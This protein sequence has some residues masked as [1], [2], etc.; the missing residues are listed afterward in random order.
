MVK[1]RVLC[2]NLIITLLTVW[3]FNSIAAEAATPTE[4]VIAYF[5]A[6][7]NG[8]TEKIKN[9]LAYNYYRKKSVLLEN[10]PN[11][12]EFLKKYHKGMEFRILNLVQNKAQA[13]VKVEQR[14]KDG[15]RKNTTLILKQAESGNWKIA[16]EIIKP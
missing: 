5:I 6:L 14:L 13:F 8:D 7:Q 3:S 15:T 11:Y 1:F 10:N 9:L 2:I 4:T 16:E 12:S